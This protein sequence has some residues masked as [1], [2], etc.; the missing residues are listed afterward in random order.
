MGADEVAGWDEGVDVTADGVDV[1]G[2]PGV[3]VAGDSDNASE[4]T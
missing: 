4:R 1:T 2:W 3:D